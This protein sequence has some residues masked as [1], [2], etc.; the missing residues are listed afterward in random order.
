MHTKIRS[1]GREQGTT[2][3][4][5]RINSLLKVIKIAVIRCLAWLLNII[6]IIAAGLLL[7]Y[8]PRIIDKLLDTVSEVVFTV[9]SLL[10]YISGA[11]T[12]NFT[13]G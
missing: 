6:I 5:E 9:K 10:E 2:Y 3:T 8:N 7:I 12:K 13:D 4:Q 11:I 1:N